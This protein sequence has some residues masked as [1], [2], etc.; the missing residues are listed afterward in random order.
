M[1]S[2]S[3]YMSL[4]TLSDGQVSV[5]PPWV[6]NVYKSK[7]K[8]KEWW[9]KHYPVVEA[10]NQYRIWNEWNNLLWYTGEILEFMDN[11]RTYSDWRG[12]KN[13]Q[14]RTIPFWVNHI[15][16]LIDKRAT[17]LASLKANFEILPPADNITEKTRMSSRII[18]PALN[19]IKLFNN[20]DLLFDENERANALYGNSFLTVEWNDRIGDKLYA[21]NKKEENQWGN[22]YKWEGEVEIKQ[23]FPWYI[24]PFPA[25]VAF[26]SPICL[27]VYEI[28]HVD[29]AREKYKDPNIQPDGRSN[30]FEFS[31][32][33]DADILSDEV[34][35]Y[36]TIV[37]PNEFMPEG[38]IIY[39]TYD[40][41]ILKSITEKYPYSHG[42]FPWEH[43]SDIKVLGRPFAYS[44]MNEL[45][46]S[47]WTYNLIGGMIKKAI[48]LTSHPK[49]MMTKGACNIQ[50]LGNGIT[51]VQH[52][53]GQ[54][55]Q[56]QR[57]DVVGADTTN[58]REDVKLTM[59]K[60]AGSFGLSNGDIPPNTRSGIQISRLQNIEK[61][62]R[63]Y[64]MGKRNDFMR[65]VL[66]K[67]ASIAG[68]YYPK[69]SK[70]HLER[71]LGKTL[72]DSI[73]VLNDTKVYTQTVLTIQNS[74]GFSD[75]LAGRVEEVAFM[76]QQ[77]PGLVS[78]QQESD[79]IGL[80]SIQKL[81]DVTTA[82]LRMAE[83]ENEA[84][85]DGKNVDAPLIEQDHI[86]HWQTHVI[87]MQ[88][89]QHASLPEKLRKK[90]EEHLGMHEMMMEQLMNAPTGIGFKQRVLTLERWPLVYKINTDMAAIQA[91]MEAQKQGDAQMQMM[92]QEAKAAEAVPIS[93][94]GSSEI[95]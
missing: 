28:L 45:K 35:I 5:K 94:E 2:L 74:A 62:N 9:Q 86:T 93:L 60:R 68:D 80:R 33:F 20:V 87:D 92:E 75:D 67:A 18:R 3:T 42:D 11:V 23:T 54:M 26:E 71:I 31:T 48:F 90:K 21:K 78:P 4:K 17:D 61:M 56:L 25:R 79:I 81:Y 47:Q 51:V 57:Y 39:N 59:Q 14:R 43:H 76:R 89:P 82:A 84:F 72:A 15:S 32:P 55:P 13:N 85:N 29:I 34:V 64:Q 24:L 63:S 8:Y 69:T 30:L 41:T 38:C 36:R 95:Q 49:W 6:D 40:G 88:T 22:E 77:L 58:F 37:K 91:E 10:F 19:H 7:K 52:K 44:I 70:E 66:L 16:D 73:D 65:R 53:A 50:A 12:F 83:G 46:A 1:T 27:Q